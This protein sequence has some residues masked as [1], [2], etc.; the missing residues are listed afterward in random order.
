MNKTA[1]LFFLL[2]SFHAVFAQSKKGL[3]YKPDTSFTKYQAVKWALSQSPNA[4]LA[5]AKDFKNITIKIYNIH[6]ITVKNEILYEIVFDVLN[7]RILF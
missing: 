2:C 5:N 3:T 7:L 4:K 6:N 1:F